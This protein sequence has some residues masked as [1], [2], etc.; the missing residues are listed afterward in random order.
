MRVF[1]ERGEGKDIVAKVQGLYNFGI[2]KKKGGPIAKSWIIDLKNGQGS[3][4]VGETKDADASF[5]MLDG[6]FELVCHGKLNP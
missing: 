4:K 5:S 1:L 2:T 6:D 3:V